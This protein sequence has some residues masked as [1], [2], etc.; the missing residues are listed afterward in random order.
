M[1]TIIIIQAENQGHDVTPIATPHGIPSPVLFSKAG[2]GVAG[3]VEKHPRP[4]SAPRRKQGSC[5]G[6]RKE[7]DTSRP[8][9]LHTLPRPRAHKACWAS[10]GDWL[11]AR[12][13]RD[14][15]SALI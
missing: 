11:K 7:E 8:S 5:L 2:N 6:S 14:Q 15:H 10:A 13:V 3:W 9:G 4:P 1:T 12:P